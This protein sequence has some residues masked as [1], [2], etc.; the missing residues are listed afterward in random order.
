M[1]LSR[2][3]TGVLASTM[4]EFVSSFY[5][6]FCSCV[7]TTLWS[8]HTES[9]ILFTAVLSGVSLA[10][11][12][13]CSWEITKASANPVVAIALYLTQRLDRLRFFLFIPA[14]VLGGL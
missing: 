14:Q 7:A 10:V 4:A 1:V 9:S 11:V 13:Y 2:Y 6:V 12:S 3:G 5:F 8:T